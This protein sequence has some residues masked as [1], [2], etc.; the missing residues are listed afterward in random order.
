MSVIRKTI[1]TKATADEMKN[2]VSTKVLPNPALSTMLES[3]TWNGY[4]LSVNSKLGNGTFTLS[5][6]KV[7]IYLELSFFGS[8]AKKQIEDA[9]DGEFKQLNK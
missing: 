8:I 1:A 3:A 5:D 6:N 4:V 9:L 7:E 2:Y